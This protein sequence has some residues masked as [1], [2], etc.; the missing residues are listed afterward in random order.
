MKEGDKHY[1]DARTLASRIVKELDYAVLTGGSSGIMEAANRG[2]Y[3]AGGQSLGLHIELPTEQTANKYLTSS[4]NFRYFFARKVCLSF[5]AESYIFYPGGYGTLDE[6]FE[7]VTLIQTRKIPAA[8]I[9]CVGTEYWN[10]LKEF[11]NKELL[12]RGVIDPGDLSFFNIT[13]DHEEI[14]RIIK[15]SPVREKIPF[16]PIAD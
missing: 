10:S 7:I 14:L 11:A 16:V 9:V 8:P 3:E 5:A 15:E 13:D 1:E 2:A 6:F 4:I 12:T